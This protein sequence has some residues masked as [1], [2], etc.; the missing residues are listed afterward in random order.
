VRAQPRR[1][2]GMAARAEGLV[3]QALARRRISG[4]F[5]ANHE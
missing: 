2:L 5:R 3:K 1:C 4:K